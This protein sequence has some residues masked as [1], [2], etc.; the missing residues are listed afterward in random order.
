MLSLIQAFRTLTKMKKRAPAPYRIAEPLW[1][2]RYGTDPSG[3]P[4][5][6]SV[7]RSA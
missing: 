2:Q 3:K 7:A 5:S 4:M 1:I 6:W